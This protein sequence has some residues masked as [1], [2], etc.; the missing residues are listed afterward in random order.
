MYTSLRCA[1]V[2]AP[3]SLEPV[4][5]KEG[6]PFPGSFFIEVADEVALLGAAV[7]AST[8]DRRVCCGL[9]HGS[10]VPSRRF[11]WLDGPWRLHEH[12]TDRTPVRV[13]AWPVTIGGKYAMTI[14][15]YRPSG[16]RAQ[17]VA[18]RSD[19]PLREVLETEVRVEDG[20]RQE[21]PGGPALLDM[22]GVPPRA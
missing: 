2:P 10:S 18:S 11:G 15:R 19:A 6:T 4:G 16:G 9:R 22:P 8:Y 14:H 1:V 3:G 21:T 13:D 20:L 17:A 7:T 12:V 5:E